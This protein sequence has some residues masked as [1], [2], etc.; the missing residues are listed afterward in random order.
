MAADPLAELDVDAM[1]RAMLD[2]MKTPSQL[3][4]EERLRRLRQE[5]EL[6]ESSRA[7][8]QAR[9]AS[10]GPGGTQGNAEKE[11]RDQA[12]AASAQ[13]RRSGL[14]S[15]SELAVSTTVHAASRG[16]RLCRSL[17]ADVDECPVIESVDSLLLRM[18]IAGRR[19]QQPRA[20]QHGL[21]RP[22][23]HRGNPMAKSC[24]SDGDARALD[25]RA[26]FKQGV[27]RR[28]AAEK[29]VDRAQLKRVF[30]ECMALSTDVDPAVA[31][32]VCQEVLDERS[33][34]SPRAARPSTPSKAHHSP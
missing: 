33:S 9:E 14:T 30:A 26:E 19:Q 4:Q 13:R 21:Q 28:V 16:G 31:L 10:A 27:L 25:A 3:R 34:S 15:P 5:R 2:S 8:A 23:S 24:G 1:R 18:S 32:E 20:E 11:L 6:A 29:A 22:Q 7:T 12:A 17:G